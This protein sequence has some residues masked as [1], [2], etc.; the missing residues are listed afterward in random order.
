MGSLDHW[1]LISY[2]IRDDK[3]YR[4]A[5]KV[6]KGYAERLQYSVFRCKLSSV[7]LEKIRLEL[8]QALAEEDSILIISLCNR[9]VERI[10]RTN[11]T[12]DWLPE[13]SSFL[14]LD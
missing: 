12:T 11:S 2:D 14:I 9:C 7:Q 13:P 4:Q 8:N 5:V 10:A 1:Y 6:I 3:R